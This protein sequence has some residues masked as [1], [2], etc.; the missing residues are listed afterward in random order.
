[1]EAQA[2]EL[3]SWQ[4]N[5]HLHAREYVED[6]H[7]SLVPER[8]RTGGVVSPIDSRIPPSSA[9]KRTLIAERHRTSEMGIRAD[10]QVIVW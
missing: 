9:H 10:A 3:W 2:P 7:S 6:V 8:V 5:G 4:N 1:M